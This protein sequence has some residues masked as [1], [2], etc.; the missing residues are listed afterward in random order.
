[1]RGIYDP[2]K[3]LALA[4]MESE[5]AEAVWRD[6]GYDALELASEACSLFGL[7]E[8]DPHGSAS[9]NIPEDVMNYA[10]KLLPEIVE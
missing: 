1:M 2:Y 6:A 5:A 4:W 3:G 7:F 10:L 8:P 9:I